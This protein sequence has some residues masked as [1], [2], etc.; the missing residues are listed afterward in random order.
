TV[1][2]SAAVGFSMPKIIENLSNIDLSGYWPPDFAWAIGKTGTWWWPPSWEFGAPLRANPLVET[3]RIAV[4]S[5]V[6]GCGVAL[7]L[8]FLASSLTAP[9]KKVY[10]L[11]KGFMN[12]IRTMPDLFWALIFVAAIGVG[13][14]AGV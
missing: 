11:A 13:P 9:N 10:L 14:F 5:S 6:I 4:V 1:F 7:P 2:A 3:F 8:A 12:L